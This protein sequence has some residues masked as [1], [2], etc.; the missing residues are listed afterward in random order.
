MKMKGLGFEKILHP[1][2]LKV[3]TDPT[4]DRSGYF[5]RLFTEAET[6]PPPPR[7]RKEIADSALTLRQLIHRLI[8]NY[9]LGL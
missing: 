3:I 2:N 6:T 7:K 9:L 1:S 5:S 4:V 8:S